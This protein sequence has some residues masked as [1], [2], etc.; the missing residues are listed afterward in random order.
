MVWVKSF[1]MPLKKDAARF[2]VGTA[3]VPQM[4]AVLVCCK[5]L[6]MVSFKDGQQVPFGAIG[7]KE[8]ETITDTYVLPELA[9]CEFK[10]A[11]DVTNPSLR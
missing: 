7:L 5:A 11:C 6:G 8:L 2:I 1:V 3:A 9:E 10:I 4:T